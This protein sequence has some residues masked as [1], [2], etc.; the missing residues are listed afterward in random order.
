MKPRISIPE[1]RREYVR[2]RVLQDCL[3]TQTEVQKSSWQCPFKKALQNH[4]MFCTVNRA[5]SIEEQNPE[6]QFLVNLSRR[7]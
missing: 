7:I 2:I 6:A 1:C 3:M 5:S 4:V